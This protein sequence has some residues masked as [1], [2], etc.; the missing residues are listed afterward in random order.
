MPS[1]PHIV[2]HLLQHHAPWGKRWLPDGIYICFWTDGSLFNLWRLLACIKTI[3]E[4]ITELLFADDC[5]L[6]THTEEALQ[7]INCF[8]NAAK[9]LTSPEEDWVVVLSMSPASVQWN[10]LLTRVASSPMMPVSKDL[11]NR[12]PKANSSFG[13]LSKSMAV[14]CFASSR[15]SRCTEPS[16]CQSFCTGAETLVLYW[17]QL[18]LLERFHQCC[19]MLSILG[20]KWQH[21]MS[22]E[23]TSRRPYCPA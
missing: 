2:L 12:L 13:R 22:N 7:H 4:L 21:Y 17:K 19:F 9:T 11:H 14:I 8:S 6:L 16:L 23:E 10:P 20:I 15:I 1:G 5:A 18:R 3:E